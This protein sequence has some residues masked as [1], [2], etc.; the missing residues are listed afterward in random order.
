MQRG[1]V[2]LVALVCLFG[3]T[4]TR[5]RCG[6]LLLRIKGETRTSSMKKILVTV[7][8]DPNHSNPLVLVEG[9][10]FEADV[11]YDPFKAHSPLFGQNCTE[12]PKTITVALVE[13][14]EEVDK[15]ELLFS[16]DFVDD[17]DGG[18]VPRAKLQ[19]GR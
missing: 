12:R 9:D 3:V 19:L 5:A 18:F 16:R 15:K 11:Y 17:G 10:K 8:P 13:N 2:S 7:A 14:G 4:T 6:P 1:I